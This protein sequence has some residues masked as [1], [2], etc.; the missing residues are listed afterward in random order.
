MKKKEVTVK[1]GRRFLTRAAVAGASL[2][3][4]SVLLQVPGIGSEGNTGFSLFQV[5]EADE[6][7]LTQTS[8][9]CGKNATWTFD[10]STGTLTIKGSG[11]IHDY[12]Y[13]DDFSPFNGKKNIKKVVIGSGIT[14]IGRST[15]TECSN[16]TSVEF[17]STLT[18]I[19]VGPLKNVDLRR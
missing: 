9:K 12:D 5:A 4:A 17:P 3:L 7:T 6:V 8:G 2:L 16:L 10:P 13:W 14:A 11:P 19:N 18:H 1:N 15:F